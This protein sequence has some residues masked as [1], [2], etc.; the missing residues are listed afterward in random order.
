ME[1]GKDVIAITTNNR[2]HAYQLKGTNHGRLGLTEWRNG[3]QQQAFDLVTTAV[4]HP[5]LRSKMHHKSFFGC[6][7]RYRRRSSRRHQ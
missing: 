5:S 4:E 6:N 2:V 7:W 1:L 3:I